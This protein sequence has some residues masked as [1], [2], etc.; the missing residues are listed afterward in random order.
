MIKD[1]VRRIAE[2]QLSSYSENTTHMSELGVLIRQ[3]L[4]QEL[5][6]RLDTFKT[7][8]GSFAK[9]LSIEGQAAKTLTSVIEPSF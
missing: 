6:E 3:T 4:T 2:L 1:T 8:L 5:R 9:D 7:H